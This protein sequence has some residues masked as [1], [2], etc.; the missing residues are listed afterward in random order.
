[1]QEK[2]TLMDLFSR[3]PTTPVTPQK[4]VKKA[5]TLQKYLVSNISNNL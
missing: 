1:M 3:V 5:K 2:T 4:I